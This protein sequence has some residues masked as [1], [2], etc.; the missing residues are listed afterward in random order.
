MGLSASVSYSTVPQDLDPRAA[1]L[2]EQGRTALG[3]GNVESAIDA[4]EAA[5]AIQPGSTAITL[6]LAEA[7]R[8][9]GLQGKA[10]HYYREALERDPRNVAAISGEGA[11]LL[12][13]GAVEKAKRNLAKLQALCSSTC[14]E[15]ES[16]AALIAHGP[17]QRVVSADAVDAS[18]VVTN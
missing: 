16:L 14:P 7:T 11:A 12:E 9:Q 17:P 3:A 2:V 13:K 15:A 5:L 4:F 18:P 1:A 8:R 6:D 10:I